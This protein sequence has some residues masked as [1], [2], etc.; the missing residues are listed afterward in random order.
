MYKTSYYLFHMTRKQS[1][2]GYLFFIKIFF[3]I[4][5]KIFRKKDSSDVAKQTHLVTQLAKYNKTI[6]LQSL[7]ALL[8]L[9]FKT[10]LY[11]VMF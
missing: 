6:L 2:F 7:C 8:C 4:N 11:F 10:A 1:L 5:L 3:E 9:M